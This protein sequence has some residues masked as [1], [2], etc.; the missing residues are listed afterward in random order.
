MFKEV[1][2][3]ARVLLRQ[4]GFA[5]VAVVTL[6]LGI[7]ANTA[8]F[9]VIDAALL[10][11]LPYSEPSRLVHLWETKRSR[12]FEQREASYPDFLDW[13]AQSGEVFEGVA[14]YTRQQYTLYTGGEAV[15]ARGAAVTAN[16]FDLLGARASVGRSFVEGEDAPDA[17]RAVVISHGMWQR[18][19]GGDRSVVGRDVALDGQSYTIVGVLPAEFEFAK[20]GEVD[21]WTPLQPTPDIAS[22]RYMHWLKVVARL[23]PGVELSAARAQM[24]AIASRIEAEDPSAHA[25]VGLRVV[26]LQEEIVGPVK[27]ILILLLGAVGFVLLIACTNV[28]NLLLARSTA[29]RREIAIRAALGASRWRIAR[30]L[31]TES[32]LLSL[33]GGAAGLMLALWGVDLLVAAIPSAQLAQMPY[34]RGLSLNANV[35]LFAAGLSLATGVL[36]GLTPA[37]AASRADLQEAMKE[38]GRSSVSRGPRRLRDMLVVAEVALALVLLVGAGL[39]M[40]SLTAMLKVDPGF[41]TRNVLTMRVALPPARY[42]DDANSARFY[43]EL[44]RRVSSVPGVRGVA[45][46][47]NLPLAAE[48]GTGTP[49]IV[50]RAAT[51]DETGE[52]HMRTVSAN[53]FDVMGLPLLKGR[54][55][56]ERDDAQAPGVLLVN[57]TFAERLFP[58]EDPVGQRVSFRF[59]AGRPPFEIVGVVGDEKVLSLDARTTPVIYFHEQQSPDSSA[60]LVVRASDGVDADSLS[61]AVTNE[62]RAI[63]SEVPVF[64]AQTLEQMVAGS[65]ATFMRR[66]PA[67]LTGVFACV[68]LLLALVGIY[69]VISYSVTQRTHEIAVRVALGARTRDVLRLVVGHGLGLALAGVVLG[70]VGALALTR[71]IAGLLFGV[72]AADPTVYGLVSALLLAVALV[73]C[74]AP[75]RRATKVDPMEALRYE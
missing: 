49:R 25:N 42:A 22:R 2:Y 71:L 26:P 40:K 29:R 16:F 15:R 3:A 9:S 17:A 47:S 28:A 30:Q 46:T 44:L 19:F 57:K 6:A 21:L 32:V 54:A 66:Y 36:F 45:E 13:R 72:S 20:L 34:L 37:L 4:P 52:S 35:L 27:S 5:L 65:R 38:G 70:T 62:V 41:D 1:R 7:G 63:D 8:I 51:D 68:A 74:L 58:G 48:G 43:A 53:Y 67:Y 23:K 55:F 31:L 61:R 39:L 11:S 73:A 64:A 14:G 24:D 75:A 10:R 60:A 56:N 12:D 69:G 33:A 50:G 18:R 59:T